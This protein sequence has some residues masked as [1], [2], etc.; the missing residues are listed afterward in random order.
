[1]ASEVLKGQRVLVT[2]STVFVG[3]A[4]C[5][6]LAAHGA[7]VVASDERL[8]DPAAAERIVRDAGTVDALLSTS[9]YRGAAR[10]EPRV[11]VQGR[12]RRALGLGAGGRRGGHAPRRA[13]QCAGVQL[14]RHA[15]LLPARGEGQSAL[16]GA[17]EAR[18]ASRPVGAR[19]AAEFAA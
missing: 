1:M 5:E 6:A 7:H 4:R 12:A 2:Q 15:D 16:P 19:E 17:P 18:G 10:P 3:P 14:R 8:D 13:G 9:A 11:V